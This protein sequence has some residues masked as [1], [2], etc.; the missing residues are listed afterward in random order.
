[1][2]YQNT[3]WVLRH[4]RFFLNSAPELSGCLPEQQCLCLAAAMYRSEQIFCSKSRASHGWMGE[5]TGRDM[6]SFFGSWL[7]DSE[8]FCFYLT[9]SELKWRLNYRETQ[10]ICSKSSFLLPSR[11][12]LPLSGR[13][14]GQ[15]SWPRSGKCWPAPAPPPSCPSARRCRRPAHPGSARR[16]RQ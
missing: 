5:N 16:G 4:R 14:Q 1:M 13:W 15:L 2:K 11:C 3:F 10:P 9:F 6:Q 8:H 12:F 7:D